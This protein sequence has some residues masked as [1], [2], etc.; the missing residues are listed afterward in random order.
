MA[1]NLRIYNVRFGDCV[2]VSFGT[3]EEHLLVDF[4]NAPSMLA[5][6][7]SSNDVFE[8]VAKDIAKRTKGRIDLVVMSHEHMDHME[9][10]RHQKAVFDGIEVRDVWMSI[11]SHPDYYTRLHPECEPEKKARLALG[12]FAARCE[13][14]GRFTAVDHRVRRLIANNVLALSNADRVQYVRDLVKT[15]QP[16]YVYRRNKPKL[17]WK[18]GLGNGVKLEVLAPEESA[19]VYYGD[20]RLWATMAA[21][22][23][24]G[25]SS[26]VYAAA[27]EPPPH[28]PVDEFEE[29][30]DSISE[31]DLAELLAIDRAANNTSLVLRMTVEGKT[32]LLPGDAEAE[33]WAMMAQKGVLGAV[34]VVK[35]AHH[36][37]RNGM[38]FAGP[39]S[40][41]DK[42]LKPGKGTTAIVSTCRNVYPASTLEGEIP[43]YQLMDELVKRCRCVIDTEHDA[44]PGKWIDYTVS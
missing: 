4:G 12:A 34:D 16:T 20:G 8:P 25:A 19:K 24:N 30:R 7:G 15:K 6:H 38:P 36:G 28:V 41:L 39:E 9:G 1:V 21:R 2:L 23:G 5:Q 14:Q 17:A 3:P 10:F 29:L 13:A 42:V 43:N 22:L 18:H 35:V 37:S 33:S 32:L 27:P 40:V 44:A 26:S 11:M 31:L